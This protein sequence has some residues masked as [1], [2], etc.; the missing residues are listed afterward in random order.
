MRPSQHMARIGKY[1][2]EK[3]LGHGGFG[4]VY[5][6]FD[7]EM[8]RRVAI[9]VLLDP[10]KLKYFEFEAFTTGKLHHK[11]IVTIYDRGKDEAENP[12]LVMEFLEGVTLK[13]VIEQRHPL[14]LL[15][16]V[17][18]MTQ[19]AE[20]LAYATSKGVVHRDIKP[21]N[22]ML[23]PDGTAKIM[24]FG[25]ALAPQRGDMTMTG[26]MVGS[27]NYM[28]PEQFT[29]P[30]VKANEQTD[31]FAFGDVYY[32]L[33]TGKHPFL[34]LA[35]EYTVNVITA[36]VNYDAPPL[37]QLAPGCPEALELL[38]HRCL[39]KDPEFRYRKFTEVALL[40]QEILADLQ[41]DRAASI[42]EEARALLAAGDVE[43]G[44]AKV[45]EAQQLE[46]GN[47]EARRLR[48]KIDQQ[49]ER[50][51]AQERAAALLEEAG[52]R[53]EERRFPEAVQ[54]LELAARL[55][56][57]NTTVREKLAVARERLDGFMRASRLVEEGRS[58]E[59]RGQLSEAMERLKA[60]LE[61][62]PQHT[63]ASRLLRRVSDKLEQRRLELAREQ[64][65][66]TALARLAAKEFAPAY[67]ALDELE[68]EQPG[69]AGTAEL[70][71]RIDQEQKEE[72]RRRRAE[73]FNLALGRTREAMQAGQLERAR[74][75]IDHL[76]ANFASEPGAAE[77][78]PALRER[79][80]TLAQAKEIAE[81]RQRAQDLLRQKAFGEALE[82]LAEGLRK[83]PGDTG[84]E[85]L[86]RS[87]V[88]LHEAHRRAEA[89]AE[90]LRQAESLRETGDAAAALTTVREGRRDFG[91][92]RALVDLARQLE[93]E[94]EQQRYAA[95]LEAL[96]SAGQ[97][98]VRA[99]KYAEA[100]ERLSA[101]EYAGEAEVRA[102]RESARAAAAIEEEKRFVEARLG[103]AARLEAEGSAEQ[104]LG[105]IQ[106][107][108]NRYPNSPQLLEALDRLRH[109]VERVRRVRAMAHRAE[110]VRREIAERR[111]KRA[112]ALVR[113][114]QRE[115]AGENAFDDLAAEIDRGLF[116]AGLEEVR[117]RVQERLA[118]NQVTDA[119]REFEPTRTVF[120][121]DPR[122]K[123]LERAIAQRRAYEAALA[124]ADR[125]RREGDLSGAEAA[126]T[127]V[128]ERA[129]DLR[130]TQMFEAIQ[131]Q[132]AEAARQAE[133]ARQEEA[134]RREAE[135]QAELARQKE[136]ERIEAERQA[137][138]ARQREA[139]RIEA[140]RQA[141][142]VRQTAAARPA[143]GPA[144]P[145]KR[146]L[147]WKHIGAAA[148]VVVLA[149]V[150]AVEIP[151]LRVKEV[152]KAAA[153]PVETPADRGGSSKLIVRPEPATPPPPPEA[154]K[155]T[156]PVREEKPKERPAPTERAAAGRSAVVLPNQPPPVQP[157]QVP[158]QVQPP[159]TAP[160][161]SNPPPGETTDPR[162]RLEEAAW[163]RVRKDDID[164]L[165]KFRGDFPNGK[166]APDAASL[167]TE[168]RRQ[169]E[170]KAAQL[171][172][173]ADQMRAAAEAAKGDIANYL[174]RLNGAFKSR[175]AKE[176][177]GV[178]PGVS[179]AILDALR[180]ATVELRDCQ[181]TPSGDTAAGTCNLV[182]Q[183]TQPRRTAATTMNVVLQK[184][185]GGWTLERLVRAP[186]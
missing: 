42:V 165:E 85:R 116:D 16:R 39:S 182:T 126:L 113:E 176:V 51:K 62:D 70:R 179:P 106:E 136:A 147:P 90:V 25:I 107:A 144:A 174:Q 55:D 125:S 23:L 156:P 1:T 50:A 86:N 32:E 103:A 71:A 173:Q 44:R 108:L 58:Q 118:A 57:T 83:F 22:I 105:E 47:R 172:Q 119:E 80:D 76:F 87:A 68:R 75:M 28:A 67:A 95:G 38:V 15:E 134:R 21:E 146:P 69:A 12:F 17:D 30:D 129:P 97:A 33:L 100:I 140:E 111:W 3:E 183:T 110:E 79:W 130:A 59:D 29:N 5:L 166:H 102:L 4:R 122:W 13:E 180:V 53:I 40:S 73:R 98:L 121:H 159:I 123:E 10:D 114:A 77:V 78:L 133:L 63:E 186:Q 152:K 124:E 26:Y 34:Q 139:E 101:E 52:K 7:P 162:A 169:A 81:Y 161:P 56:G 11:N 148:A 149:I 88:E 37:G 66:R 138:L 60:A 41:H 91:E 109:V 141:E 155:E 185:G 158:V 45:L 96:L 143:G 154:K 92:D 19:V 72:E 93:V 163:A 82:C 120:A 171:K 49:I 104:G 43:Q 8:E 150:A 94:V 64:A 168:L 18:L 157:K 160:L 24:D 167:I 128:I 112:Q 65:L 31:I 115:F 153:V 142:L 170:A 27:R 35:K 137:A 178:W 127:G 84:L 61:A 36:I 6:A 99:G 184:A 74:E 48:E 132:R 135:R 177:T 89:I 20:G 46:P 117:R 54:S 145:Q 164:A 131:A 151:R 9:K 14:S 2:V 181:I 175:K